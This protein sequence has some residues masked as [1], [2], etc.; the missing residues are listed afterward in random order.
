MSTLVSVELL[1]LRTT[2]AWIGYVVALVALSAIGAAGQLG[3]AKTADLGGPHFQRDVLA[4]AQIAGLL[5]LLVGITVVTVERRHGTVTR[6]FLVT[7]RRERVLV[8]KEVAAF[9]VGALLAVVSF[10]VVLAVAVPWLSIEGASLHVG[11]VSG[12]MARTL[13]A[14]ALWGALGVGFGAIVQSQTVALIAAILW[15]VLVEPLSAALLR[16]V[17]LDHVADALPAAALQALE[18]NGG[19]HVSPLAG[20]AIGVAYV[21]ALGALGVVRVLRSDIT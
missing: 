11:T 7:P 14:A 16:L 19:D 12:L 18:A 5:A 4:S 1:K 3:P 20:G 2:R 17:E 21:L 15:V 8:A 6:T 10:V 9:A 13:L